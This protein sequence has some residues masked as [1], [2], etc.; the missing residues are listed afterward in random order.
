[1]N[2]YEY[3]VKKIFAEFEVPTPKGYL[4]LDEKQLDAAYKELGAEKWGIIKAQVP[5]GGRGKAGGIKVVDSMDQAKV[6]FRS[7]MGM[8]IKGLKVEKILVE[9]KIRIQDE[10]F[11]SFTIDPDAE[12]PVLLI[13]P[14]GGM[15][16]E[17]VA[18]DYPEALGKYIIEPQSGLPSYAIIAM[19][20]KLGFRKDVWHQII[21]VTRKL[22]RVFRQREATLV[23]INPLVLTKELELIAA[24]GKLSSD[25]NALF[26]QPEIEKLQGEFKDMV[27][28]RKG[29][30]YVDLGDGEV[31]LLCAGAGMTMLTMDLVQQLGAKAQC[32]IDMSH[33]INPES[34][35]T[36][37]EVLYTTP[38]VKCILCNMFGGLTR[39][40]EVATSLLQAMNALGGKSPKP[41]VM[42]IQGTNAEEGR[43]ILKDAGYE[44]YSELEDTLQ[45]LKKLLEANR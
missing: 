11:L 35:K 33:G 38:S 32:F 27:L 20:E 25:D 45:Y 19:L 13:S 12:L 34:F 24:D 29:V 9:E 22:Y 26:R 6:A 8:E 37:L 36:A 23:E 21:N 7:I 16:I 15:D 28:K 3:Q 2:L 43:K 40:N 17:E 31:G 4:V 41:M 10:Y 18:R 30:D 5:V 42:R 44:A 39:M 1:M 14:K